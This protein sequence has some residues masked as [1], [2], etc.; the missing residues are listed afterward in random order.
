[1]VEQ[2]DRLKKDILNQLLSLETKI[3]F[4]TKLN[5][6]DFAVELENVMIPILNIYLD[7]AFENANKIKSNMKAIDLIDFERKIGVQVTVNDTTKKIRETL[8]K[9][10]QLYETETIDELYIF[11]LTPKSYRKKD[12]YVNEFFSTQGIITI[13]SICELSEI[14]KLE[15]IL[16]YLNS[17]SSVKFDA[18]YL[19]YQHQIADYFVET[20]FYRKINRKLAESRVVI[21]TGNA[22]IGKTFNSYKI[23]NEYI[24][25]GYVP[26]ELKNL[27]SVISQETKAILFVDDFISHTS[28]EAIDYN[29]VSLICS[30]IDNIDNYKNLVILLNSRNKILKDFNMKEDR[31]EIE[32]YGKFTINQ[33][34][35]TKSEKLKL[36]KGYLEKNYTQDQLKTLFK[37]ELFRDYCDLLIEHNQFNPRLIETFVDMNQS[38]TNIGYELLELFNKP[39][40]LYKSQFKQ[41]SSIQKDIMRYIW[42]S[43]GKIKKSLLIDRLQTKYEDDYD[44]INDEITTLID[45]FVLVSSELEEDDY[46]VVVYS[47]GVLDHLNNRYKKDRAISNLID[48]NINREEALKFLNHEKV[49]LDQKEDILSTH[50]DKLEYKDKISLISD[51]DL[52]IIKVS[53]LDEMDLKPQYNDDIFKVLET[54]DIIEHIKDKE[55]NLFDRWGLSELAKLN[56]SKGE[57]STI[58]Q[59]LQKL[60]QELEWKIDDYGYDYL[61]EY[62]L[63]YNELG[64]FPK[65]EEYLCEFEYDIVRGITTE[66]YEFFMSVTS[67][68]DIV[69]ENYKIEAALNLVELLVIL[70][71]YKEMIQSNFNFEEIDALIQDTRLLKELEFTD[72]ESLFYGFSYCVD[73]F[74]NEGI[75]VSGF[76]KKLVEILEKVELLIEVLERNELD[77]EEYYSRD[78]L[79]S[80]FEALCDNDFSIETEEEIQSAYQIE[81][82]KWKHELGM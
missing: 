63:Y 51:I 50:I 13:Q 20:E 43:D 77:F 40:K 24:D 58:D 35:Y 32:K 39:D 47:H 56:I 81:K 78:Y 26:I 48:E 46:N 16:S 55:I 28:F 52:E 53:L 19:K 57:I 45:T 76:S 72:L 30:V 4:L 6:N 79:E 21:I 17:Y 70:K 27:E 61:E 42:L 65:V 66:L 54:D 62:K 49:K 68:L 25:K 74:K 75:S 8:V 64:D 67:D 11:V 59:I 38:N 1:M 73:D 31:I 36:L 60:P 33:T 69:L 12:T 2:I 44:E 82:T 15:Q 9:S 37:R 34:E 22:G 41:L 7:G 71:D 18:K 5:K 29:N 3:K 10:V 80:N 14:E 23:F